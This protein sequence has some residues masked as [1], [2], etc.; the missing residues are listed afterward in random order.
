MNFA[1]THGSASDPFST[2]ATKLGTLLKVCHSIHYLVF[3]VDPAYQLLSPK[4]LMVE[5]AGQ[6]LEA[7]VGKPG[8]VGRASQPHWGPSPAATDA[9][10]FRYVMWCHVCAL[11]DL[12][13][14][15][16]SMDHPR[17]SKLY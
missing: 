7:R 14:P 13:F 11:S 15:A 10:H 16:P 5:E 2:D 4:V 9:E 1:E 12:C 17:G 6:V 3:D 8:P